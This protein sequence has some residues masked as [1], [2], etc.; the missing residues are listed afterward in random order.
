M[1]KTSAKFGHRMTPVAWGFLEVSQSHHVCPTCIH[2]RDLHF[3][4][5]G[6]W[7]F[8]CSLFLQDSFQ[9]WRLLPWKAAT[10]LASRCSIIPNS[11]V[12]LDFPVFPLHRDSLPPLHGLTCSCSSRFLAFPPSLGPTLV[13][14]EETF[15][16]R[17]RFG[18]LGASADQRHGALAW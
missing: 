2:G 15:H 17:G 9:S 7:L 11:R 10:S 3:S 14:P 16:G 12:H 5:P 13:L 6:P 8:L 18:D 1:A 4:L